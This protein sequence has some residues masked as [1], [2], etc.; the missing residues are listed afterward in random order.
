MLV[1]F[2][3]RTSYDLYLTFDRFFPDLFSLFQQGFRLLIQKVDG[4]G[5]K[6]F[7]GRKPEYGPGESEGVL[8]V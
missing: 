5:R 7:G 3:R 2:F 4:I 6:T 1:V 8:V